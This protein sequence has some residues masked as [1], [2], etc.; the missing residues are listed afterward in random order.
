MYKDYEYCRVVWERAAEWRV[1]YF[2]YSVIRKALLEEDTKYNQKDKEV[3][4]VVVSEDGF[5]LKGIRIS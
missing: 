3:P 2:V 4:R 1:S 5:S